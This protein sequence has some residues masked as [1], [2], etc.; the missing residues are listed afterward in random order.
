[1]YIQVLFVFY[2]CRSDELDRIIMHVYYIV[3]IV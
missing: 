3:K 1:M 2:V